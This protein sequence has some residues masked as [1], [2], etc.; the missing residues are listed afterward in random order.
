MKCFDVPI[1][2]IECAIV[3]LPTMLM[4]MLPISIG[5]W[6]VRESLLIFGFGFF[7]VPA[8]TALTISIL[9]GLALL[10]SL[11]PGSF[12]FLFKRV[13]WADREV[14]PNV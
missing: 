6:G 11:L 7:G 3:M 14:H 2:F 13:G 10:V 12:L 5:G 9:W 8:E 1:G 4:V